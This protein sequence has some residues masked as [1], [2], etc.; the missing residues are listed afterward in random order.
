MLTL[1]IWWV[2]PVNLH[3]S[4]DLDWTYWPWDRQVCHL[5]VGS[6]TK[7][8]WELDVQNLNRKNISVVDKANFAPSAWNLVKGHQVTQ[9]FLIL[10]FVTM[11]TQGEAGV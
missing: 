10:L 8:G 2:P 1:Q 9:S 4:C 3:T 11:L 6:W 5:V 7:T